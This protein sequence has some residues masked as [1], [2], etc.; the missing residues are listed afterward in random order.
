M[1][2]IGGLVWGAPQWLWP[3]IG[4]TIFIALLTAWNDW[5]GRGVRGGAL[6]ERGGG[7]AM[8]LAFLLKMIAVVLMSVC[9][10]DP[11]WSG[12][13]ARPQANLFPILVDTSESM[14]MLSGR[15]MQTRAEQ[16][17]QTLD[18]N[19]GWRVRLAQDFDVRPYS[20]ASRLESGTS[21]DMTFLGKSSDLAA[22]L[23]GLKERLR[24]RPVAG[25]FC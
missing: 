23:F 1:P 11:M 12:T 2:M 22:S 13:R 3:A 7:W 14:T 10:L 5:F 24:D 15:G 8:T 4:I 21:S 6:L 18:E 9:L 17:T 20:F 16:M 25:V 19:N